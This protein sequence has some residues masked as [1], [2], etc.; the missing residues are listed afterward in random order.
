[1]YL[2][3]DMY[4]GGMGVP[5]SRPQ[6]RQWYEKSAAAGFALAKKKVQTKKRG[7]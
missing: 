4:A 1:M 5:K 7:N 2:L 3:G 6:A